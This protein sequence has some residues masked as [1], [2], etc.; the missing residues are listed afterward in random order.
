M[1]IERNPQTLRAPLFGYLRLSLLLMI[2][3][4][5]NTTALQAATDEVEI[6]SQGFGDTYQAALN[7]ALLTG[8]QQVRGLEASTTKGLRFDLNA[9]TDADTFLHLNGKLEQ[10]VDTYVNSKGWIK[11]YRVIDVKKPATEDDSWQVTINAIIPVY[12]QV[13][14]D[15]QRLSIAV[16]PFRIHHATTAIDNSPASPETIAKQLANAI[17]SALV[18]SQHYAVLNRD[19]TGELNREHQL[20]A[21]GAVNPAEASRLGEQLGADFM[22]LGQI[23][24]FTI[25]HRKK[26]FYN[27]DFGGQRAEIELSYHMIESATG[28]IIWSDQKRWFKAVDEDLNHFTREDAPHPLAEIMMTLGNE[29]VA[30]L[31]IAMRGEPRSFTSTQATPRERPLTSTP[32]SSD[33]PISW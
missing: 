29:I 26:E 11:N 4:L 23:D 2:I 32:G 28:K 7:S 8:V 19:F 5:S 21:S 31:L 9:I 1:N 12:K 20:W 15:D 6:K 17:Q 22:L 10:T 13:T 30:D 18:R 24:R 16:L 3:G 33:Q 27:T 14:P 25:N